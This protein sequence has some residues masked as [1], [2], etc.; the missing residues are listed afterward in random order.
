MDGFVSR[1]I[2][3]GG[4]H[5]GPPALVLQLT[6]ASDGGVSRFLHVRGSRESG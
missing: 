5:D 1:F 3:A 4:S 2:A 6:P